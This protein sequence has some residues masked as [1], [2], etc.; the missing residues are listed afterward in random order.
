MPTA[1]YDAHFFFLLCLC[2]WQLMYAY[3][4]FIAQNKKQMA[5]GK[6]KPQKQKYKKEKGK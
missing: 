2:V 5:E 6:S 4:A 3:V 1:E